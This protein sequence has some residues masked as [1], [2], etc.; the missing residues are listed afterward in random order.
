MCISISICFVFCSQLKDEN[1]SAKEEMKSLEAKNTEIVSQ[2]TQSEQKILK[3]EGELNDKVVV[4]KEKSA[5]VSEN[6][7]LKALIAQQNDRLKL[8]HQ[9]IE[10]S[11][12]ELS[13][14]ETIISQLSL[15]TS[16]EVQ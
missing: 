7:E 6:A 13:T 3:L 10:D 9:E 16:K 4:L 5:L 14:L 2:L 12:E 8:C 15:G 11:R 1:R